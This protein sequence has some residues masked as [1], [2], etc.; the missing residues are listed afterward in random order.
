MK[1]R[2]F[3][4]KLRNGIKGRPEDEI[5]E[6]V[7]EYSG[8][9]DDRIKKGL[10][11]EDAVK[12]FGDVFELAE[13]L[14]NKK[15]QMEKDPIGDAANKLI[16]KIERIIKSVSKKSPKELSI[17]FCEAITFLLILGILHIPVNLLIRLGKDVFYILPSPVNR[18]FYRLWHF[19]LDLSYYVFS[20]VITLRCLDNIVPTDDDTPLPKKTEKQ[21]NVSKLIINIMVFALKMFSILILLGLS[22]YLLGMTIIL[23]LCIYLFFKGVTYYGFYLVMITLFLLGTLFFSLLYDYVI[24]KKNNALFFT[25]RLTCAFV[26]LSIGCGIAAV[27]ITDTEFINSAPQSITTEVLKEE[28]IMDKNTVFV[29]NV[30]DYIV[31]NNIKNVIVEFHYYPIANQISTNIKKEDNNVYLNWNIES[32]Y[33]KPE[34][35]KDVISHLAEKKVYNY[36]LEPIITITSNEENIETIKNNRLRYYQGETKYFSCNFTRTYYVEMIRNTKDEK[37]YVVLSEN[38]SDEIATIEINN[39]L[40]NNLEVGSFY[41]FTFKTYQSYIDT[42]INNIFNENEIESIKKTEKNISEH[43]QEESCSKFY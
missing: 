20:V 13:E 22:I 11:E 30:S 35:I 7:K 28:L 9:I 32:V 37:N 38:G 10:S 17:L 16:I 33:V 36:Y 6:I 42:D 34:L 29:G 14:S 31:D 41:E 21:F 40:I 3:L 25:I 19:V 39:E 23:L 8:Y 24:D 26:L 43:I 18:I 27:E 15:E 5:E 12:T 2:T 1:K 4:T